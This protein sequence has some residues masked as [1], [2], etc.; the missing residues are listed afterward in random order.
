MIKLKCWLPCGGRPGNTL[1]DDRGTSQFKFQI[2]L[3]PWCCPSAMHMQK[4]KETC[5]VGRASQQAQMEQR[6]RVTTCAAECCKRASSSF[7]P[8]AP[9]SAAW[10]LCASATLRDSSM[11]LSG[12]TPVAGGP[13]P[14]L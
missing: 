3:S 14:R 13:F 4:A 2:V 10:G 7:V 9:L 11:L 1:K 5:D 12:L 8:L 6:Q